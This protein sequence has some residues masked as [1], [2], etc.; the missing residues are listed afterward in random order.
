MVCANENSEAVVSF[1]QKEYCQRSLYLKDIDVIH[2]FSGSLS[3]QELI[4]Y[5][6]ETDQFRMQGSGSLPILENN[7]T[8]G[9]NCLIY[10]GQAGPFKVFDK[11]FSPF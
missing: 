3:K 10:Y 1:E 11:C 2:D 5:L 7:S 9:N 4:D 6:L 8:V